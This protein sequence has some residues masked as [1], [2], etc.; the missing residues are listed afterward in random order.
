MCGCGGVL[1]EREG[2]LKRAGYEE[3]QNLVG[4][5]NDICFV[6]RAGVCV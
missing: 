4:Y 5:F 1:I 6:G 3:R 2:V